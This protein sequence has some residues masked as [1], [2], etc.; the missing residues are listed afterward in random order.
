MLGESVNADN[1][2]KQVSEMQEVVTETTLH[3]EEIL[4]KLCKIIFDNEYG[5]FNSEKMI[6]NI[7][8]EIRYYDW[9]LYS[10]EKSGI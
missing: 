5:N 10:K 8:K 1:D 2:R 6:E 7:K 9:L 4:N 3:Y